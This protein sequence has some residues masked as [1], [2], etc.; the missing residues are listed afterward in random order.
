MK[1]TET[2]EQLAEYTGVALETL[3]S[4]PLYKVMDLYNAMMEHK[5]AEA[6]LNEQ[7]IL[8]NNFAKKS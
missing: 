2:Y 7:I 8:V 3:V 5:K 4:C 1:N 6:K